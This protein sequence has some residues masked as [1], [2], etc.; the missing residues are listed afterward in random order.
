MSA[1][2]DLLSRAETWPKDAQDDL[3]SAALI[4][5]RSKGKTVADLDEQDYRIIAQRLSEIAAGQIA[6]DEAVEAVFAKYRAS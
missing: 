6:S 2:K 3:L 1:L 4:I 5:E